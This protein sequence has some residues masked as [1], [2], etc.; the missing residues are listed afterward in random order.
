MRKRLPYRDTLVGFPDDHDRLWLLRTPEFTGAISEY[1][2][3]LTGYDP[4]FGDIDPKVFRY[5]GN[6][7]YITGQYAAERG[8]HVE[9]LQDNVPQE[10][11]K[12]GA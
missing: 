4:R 6:A 9:E 8:W 2:S 7:Y 1:N 11:N 3:E 5:G 12:Q 10:A